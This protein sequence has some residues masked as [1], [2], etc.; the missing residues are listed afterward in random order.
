MTKMAKFRIFLNMIFFENFCT[1]RTTLASSLFDNLIFW[2]LYFLKIHMS[3]FCQLNFSLVPSMSFYP[4]FI[5]TLSGFLKKSG[6]NLDKVIFP[7]LSKFYPDFILILSRFFKISLYPDFI[8]IL[9][10]ENLEKIKN[11]SR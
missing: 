11:N 4:D 5:L 9:S 10:G 3:N 7:T 1:R 8:M 6:W 2:T